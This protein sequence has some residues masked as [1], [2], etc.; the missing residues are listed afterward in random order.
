[1]AFLTAYGEKLD[2]ARP[3]PEYPRPQMVRDSY[4][5]LNGLWRYA[6]TREAQPPGEWD[7]EIVVPFSPESPSPV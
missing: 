2:P 4:L 6:I 7:G 1:M 3:L 5:N